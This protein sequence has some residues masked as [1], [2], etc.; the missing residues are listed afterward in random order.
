[1]NFVS[2]FKFLILALSAVSTREQLCTFIHLRIAIVKQEFHQ[3]YSLYFILQL[4]TLK[5]M[6]INLALLVTSFFHCSNQIMLSLQW[7]NS[8]I[9]LCTVIVLAWQLQVLDFQNL[10]WKCLNLLVQ[11]LDIVPSHL[12]GLVAG[13]CFVSTVDSIVY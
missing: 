5:Q 7:R 1:M 2:T 11:Q 4:I 13:A 3:Q 9:L 6:V 12:D 8:F 10:Q